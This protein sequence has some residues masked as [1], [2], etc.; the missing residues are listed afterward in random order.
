MRTIQMMVLMAV[1]MMMAVGCSK[2]PPPITQPA[3]A[4]VATVTPPP[5]I[6]PVVA[7]PIE[8]PPAPPPPKTEPP[9]PEPIVFDVGGLKIGDRISEEWENAHCPKQTNGQADV[10]PYEDIKGL[11]GDCTAMYYFENHQLFGVLLSYDP[12]CFQNLVD[13]YTDKFGCKPHKAS[14]SILTNRLNAKFQNITVVWHTTTGD[15]KL[16]KY[17]SS[18]NTGFGYI[19]TPKYIEYIE[20][21]TKE[22]KDKAKSQL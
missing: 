11:G 4:P 17:G 7:K 16:T 19:E 13:L 14:T 2:S 15:F 8:Q 9:K 3:P 5:V 1:V 18:V 20:R 22:Q 12:D 21:Q 10:T 6:N